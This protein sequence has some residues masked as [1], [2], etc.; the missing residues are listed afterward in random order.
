MVPYFIRPMSNLT[1]KELDGGMPWML[2]A[3]T[4]MIINFLLSINLLCNKLR[5]SGNL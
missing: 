5:L 4:L 3:Y 1:G 2:S